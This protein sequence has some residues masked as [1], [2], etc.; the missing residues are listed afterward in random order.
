MI[1]PK[2]GDVFEKMFTGADPSGVGL[3]ESFCE[4]RRC[5]F[6]NGTAAITGK[7]ATPEEITPLFDSHMTPEGNRILA[8]AL[9]VYLGEHVFP[10]LPGDAPGRNPR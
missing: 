8:E 2:E 1:L 5:H 7:V 4:G 3:V 10:S 9:A 6:F